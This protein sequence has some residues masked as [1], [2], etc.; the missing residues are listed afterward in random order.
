MNARPGEE[1]LLLDITTL[2]INKGKANQFRKKGIETVE[3]L[4]NYLPRKY[5][6]FSTVTPI[7]AARDGDVVSVI[8]RVIEMKNTNKFIKVKIVDS[9]KWYMHVI[10]FN[11]PYIAKQIEEGDVVNF[12]GKVNIDENYGTK[13]MV[14]PMFFS[15]DLEKYKKIVPIYSKISG[16][17]DDFLLKS[18]DTALALTNKEDHL[19][20]SIIDKYQL[21][22]KKNAIK[23]I[24]QPDNDEDIRM[25]R[26][27]IL[28]DDLFFFGT[29]LKLQERDYVEASSMDIRKADTINPFIKTLPFKLTDDQL[30][31]VRRI[32]IDMRAGKKVNA[33]VQG[34]VGSGKTIT[35]F[36]LMFIMAENNYQSALM[37]PTNVLAKQHY[38]ELKEFG[39]KM[40]YEVALLTGT[41]KKRDRKKILEGLNDGSIK[42]IVGTHAVIS[43]E[44]EFDNL[45]LTIVDEEH[46][47]GVAQREKINK[48][49]SEGVHSVT[50]SATP[51]PRSLALTVHGSNVKVYNITQMPQGRK[52]VRT[53]LTNNEKE[54]YDMMK[55]EIRDGRQAYVV[56]PLIEESDSDVMAGV[57]SVDEVYQGM[58]KYFYGT[59]IRISVINGKMKK[60]DI[61]D[62]LERFARHESDILISTTIIE[63]GVNVPNATVMAI[64]NA[65]RFGLAQLHQLRG[66]VGRGT[67]QS[68]CMLISE[69][70]SNEK[71]MAMVRT[72]NGFEIA[73][74]DLQLRGAG[75]F[76]GTKQ[77]G[78]NK[79]VML[80]LAYPKLFAEIRHDI[81]EIFKDETRKRKYTPFI[82]KIDDPAEAE[83]DD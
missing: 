66:R 53:L 44:V 62:E 79:Y 71:L 6:D 57:K 10:W 50:M 34:D 56:C 70:S 43:S 67:H 28:F 20:P 82:L 55:D 4:V 3:D 65:E 58:L 59:G 32:F 63:V 17:S 69:K 9:S 40:G 22:S 41:T 80:M 76:I 42:M 30:N 36:L 83:L 8:G 11:Q 12:C 54:A 72:T 16:M 15:K 74:A 14:N 35:A 64:S 73:E 33:L 51:I 13:N 1:V 52:P 46:R 7:S 49:T 68:Y 19:E 18:I 39:E 38:D 37:A 31:T 78:D 29:M 60:A 24:H 81:D 61:E 25:A 77:S 45:G 5:H 75:D 23:G 2:G 48:K 47:F 21:Y 26:K 27:R